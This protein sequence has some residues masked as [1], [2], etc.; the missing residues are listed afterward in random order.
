MFNNYFVYTG[1]IVLRR[2][3]KVQANLMTTR[4]RGQSTC[5]LPLYSDYSDSFSCRNPDPTC[6]YYDCG[7]QCSLIPFTLE[8]PCTFETALEDYSELDIDESSPECTVSDTELKNTGDI[9]SSDLE[10]TQLH[11]EHEASFTRYID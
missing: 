10:S 6:L 3:V 9:D 8:P 11:E 7:I 1:N 4:V 5:N 2:N